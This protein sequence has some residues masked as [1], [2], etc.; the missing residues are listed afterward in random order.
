MAL[1]ALPQLPPASVVLASAESAESS[2]LP[3]A[4]RLEAGGVLGQ[5]AFSRTAA[6]RGKATA[7]V[8]CLFMHI[9][10]LMHSLTA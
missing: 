4:Q 9:K 5:A 1:D 7:I 8:Y 2:R 10:S 3:A 6:E